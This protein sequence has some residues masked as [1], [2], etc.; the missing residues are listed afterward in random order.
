MTSIM[1]SSVVAAIVA[2]PLS[3]SL[4]LGIGILAGLTAAGLVLTGAF[5]TGFIEFGWERVPASEHD[6]SSPWPT[7]KRRALDYLGLRRR[8]HRS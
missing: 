7:I 8:H 5:V 2:V 6:G 1:V 4:G 3:S